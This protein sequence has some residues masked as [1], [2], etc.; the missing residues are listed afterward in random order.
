MQS[1]EDAHNKICSVGDV[2]PDHRRP[3]DHLAIV[4]HV[5]QTEQELDLALGD[6]VVDVENLANGYTEVQNYIMR[7]LFF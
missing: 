4:K 3:L 7:L 2:G 1:K 5:A 6:I